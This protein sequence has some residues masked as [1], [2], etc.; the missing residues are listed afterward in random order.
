M[1]YCYRYPNL[2]ALLET[3]L[4]SIIITNLNLGVI[5]KLQDNKVQ[6]MYIINRVFKRY[7]SHVS[8]FFSGQSAI[9][10]LYLLLL[11]LLPLFFPI[12]LQA[13][14]TSTNQSPSI[15]NYSDD[16]ITQQNFAEQEIIR[17]NQ[18]LEALKTQ[19]NE[20]ELSEKQI[21]LELETYKSKEALR[22]AKQNRLK[23]LQILLTSTL[24]GNKDSLDKDYRFAYQAIMLGS[25]EEGIK[26]FKVY[27][28]KQEKEDNKILTNQTAIKEDPSQIAKLNDKET[29]INAKANFILGE[30]LTI[31]S[32]L[33]SALVHFAES[34]KQT[35][36]I[37]ISLLSL[38]NMA[39]LFDL[40]NRQ[41]ELCITLKRFDDDLSMIIANSLKSDIAAKYFNIIDDL[42][43]TNQCTGSINTNQLNN[44]IANSLQ[45]N[46]LTSHP[47]LPVNTQ[48]EASSFIT[49]E[50]Q[51]NYS[52]KRQLDNL[53]NALLDN[54]QQNTNSYSNILSPSDNEISFP[55][56]SKPLQPLDPSL[57][58][59]KTSTEIKKP[60]MQPFGD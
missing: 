4:N 52:V 18:E 15:T 44:N 16:I 43:K 59:Y 17:L 58:G 19:I 2:Q 22:I 49:D 12:T 26:Q 5:I 28:A 35:Q 13:A 33:R 3:V 48:D 37:D 51:A 32:D 42:K 50:P 39:S 10:Y 7:F 45:K 20:K 34:Y 60:Y 9:D 55:K 1:L 21:N 27:L 31:E 36:S 6:W 29:S 24:F 23:N 46:E 47:E 25:I 41:D 54:F 40:L 57:R 14:T 56:T 8:N 11:L 53:N 30:L 38:I